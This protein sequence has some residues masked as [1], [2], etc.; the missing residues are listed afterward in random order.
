MSEDEEETK[1]TTGK[2][3]EPPRPNGEWVEGLEKL[4]H[5]LD[6]ISIIRWL[7][8]NQI[9]TETGKPYEWK[10]YM[11][12]FD[13]MRD[14][15]SKQVILKAAQIG[16]STLAILKTLWVA[17]HRALDIIYTLP[18]QSD[19]QQFAGG[20]INRIIAQNPVLKEMVKDHDTVEQKAVGDNII[21]YRG[22]FSQKAAT[23]VSSDLNVYDEVDSSKQDV[24][25]QYSTRLQA[26]DKGWEWYFSHPSL[27]D[28]GVD[29][30]WKLSDQKHWFITCPHCKKEQF[31]SWPES[32]DEEKGEYVCKYCNGVLSDDDRRRGRWVQRYKDR[33]FSGYWIPLL[34]APWVSA[35]RIIQYKNEKSEEYFY[36][37]VLGLPYSGSKNKV[38]YNTIMNCVRD[39]VNDYFAERMVIGVDTGMGIHLV[40]G[41]QQGIFF[42]DSSKDY[43][44]FERLMTQN[45]NA[46]AVFDAGGDLQKPR[47]L[48]QK[49]QGRV[50]FCYYRH[51]R[52]SQEL[53]KWNN[54][55]N[56]CVV[57]RN[58]MIQ[59]LIDEFATDRMVLNG[60]KDDWFDYWTH[61]KAIY[62]EEEENALGVK[63]KRWKRAGDDHLV[64]ATVYWRAGMDRFGQGKGTLGKPKKDLN[65]QSAHEIED[66]YTT[67]NPISLLNK[68]SKRDWRK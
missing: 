1:S 16:F 26:S 62:A 24:I 41:N 36:N 22:T 20:K 65:I 52:K 34:I 15:S 50:F 39:T 42:Y 33:A 53:V 11:F 67:I 30:Y 45:K 59:L 44:T 21:Y 54:D 38:T 56:T 12:M 19:V 3:S 9:K 8:K 68:T 48:A 47:E 4:T 51:D 29:K 32:V 66:G 5:M 25:E 60:D 23:M 10:D 2:H 7:E 58:A 35:E 63:V 46:V 64:H 6:Q 13:P 61:W 57:D 55:E 27:D 14:M 17:K 18:T 43:T 40:A 31:M 28:V 37:K 49:Y